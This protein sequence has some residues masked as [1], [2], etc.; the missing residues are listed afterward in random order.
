MVSSIPNVVS[1][2]NIFRGDFNLFFDTSLEYQGANSIL[3]KKSVVI[4]T[5]IVEPFDLCVYGELET[6][7]RRALYFIKAINHPSHI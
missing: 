7:R 2:C 1:K 6:L 3:K 4:I 5:E